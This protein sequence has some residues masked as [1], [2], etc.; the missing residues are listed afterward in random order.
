MVMIHAN[1][2]AA[3]KS[4]RRCMGIWRGAWLWFNGAQTSGV[5]SESERE[6]CT[7]ICRLEA[8]FSHMQS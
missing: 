3:G 5:A 2:S 6:A 7:H 1:S 8:L 4:E